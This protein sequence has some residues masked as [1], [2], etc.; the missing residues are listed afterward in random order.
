MSTP[1]LRLS[2]VEVRLGSKTLVGPVDLEVEA[3]EHLLL[4]G[5]SG[6]G[7]STL[8]R[9]IAG[10]V[11]PTEGRIEFDGALAAENGKETLPPHQRGVGF[12]FQ[13]GA[14]W[15]HMNVRRT[16]DFTLDQC[17][18]PKSERAAR[19]SELLAWVELEGFEKRTPGTL[20]GGEAQRLA[21]ARALAPRPR[22]LLLDEPLGPL[23]AEL[24]ASLLTK[25]DVLQKE[26]ELT[27]IHVTHDP[28]EAQRIASRRLRLEGGTLRE[29]SLDEVTR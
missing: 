24:R 25:L 26:L 27:S 22:L 11:T 20:S 6:S 15:P 7:K 16:L 5:R 12:L 29:D 19:I 28:E 8:L 21:L 23:D 2:K 3:G 14:L 9:A 17:R 13:G 10:L 18:V 1:L 4:V